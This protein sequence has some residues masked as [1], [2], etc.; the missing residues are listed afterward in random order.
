KNEVSVDKV[1]IDIFAWAAGHFKGHKGADLY[2][3]DGMNLLGIKPVAKGQRKL[4]SK[5][6]G[7]GFFVSCTALME[8]AGVNER[9]K[10]PAEW[11]DREKMLVVH[12]KGRK[13]AK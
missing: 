9:R 11:D 10:V 1:G 7:T 2:V 5:A 6:E 4:I 3:D 8:Q 13:P 12:L